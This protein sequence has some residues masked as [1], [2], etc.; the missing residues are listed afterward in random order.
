[1]FTKMPRARSNHVIEERTVD[2]TLCRVSSQP[3]PLAVPVPIM[4]APFDI[5]V[6]TS[7]KSTFIGRV[8]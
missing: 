1:M 2:G 5:T 6:L 8:E 4:A 3:S 7:A